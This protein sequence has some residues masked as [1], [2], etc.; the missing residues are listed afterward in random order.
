MRPMTCP[1]GDEISTQFVT[2]ARGRWKCMTCA[3]WISNTFISNGRL[4]SKQHCVQ[5]SV[6][7]MAQN[8]CRDRKSLYFIA[9]EK[10]RQFLTFRPVLVFTKNLVF[11]SNLSD[12][13]VY[14]CTSSWS[15]GKRY[16][17]PGGQAWTPIGISIKSPAEWTSILENLKKYKKISKNTGK[18]QK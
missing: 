3:L 16:S 4:D 13:S 9:K 2:L 6:F 12:E 11:D 8:I 18:S 17:K 10:M 7:S 1:G 15:S 14:V 5:Q